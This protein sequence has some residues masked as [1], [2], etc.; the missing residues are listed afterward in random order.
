M[1]KWTIDKSGHD[2]R[3][4]HACMMCIILAHDAID[5]DKD[6]EEYLLF[7]EDGT[8][9]DVLFP[10]RIMQRMLYS[11]NLLIFDGRY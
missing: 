4:I 8:E 7:A 9:E 11:A 6:Y 1:I 3:F 2:K 5:N 10:G